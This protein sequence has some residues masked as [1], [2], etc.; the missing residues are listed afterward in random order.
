MNL[1]GQRFGRLVAMRPKGTDA[2][3][4]LLWRCACDCGRT[5]TVRGRW[6]RLGLRKSCGCTRPPPFGGNG[7]RPHG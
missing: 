6:L 7:G 2:Q 1:T 5:I 3:A 4:C